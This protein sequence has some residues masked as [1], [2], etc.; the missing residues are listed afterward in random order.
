[1]TDLSRVGLGTVQFGMHY[2]VSNRV[3][4]PDEREVAAILERAV[5]RGVRYLDTASA[6]GDAEILLGRHL[7]S[8]HNLRIVTKMPPVR[9]EHIGARHKQQWLDALALSLERLKVSA[10]Y[11]LLVHQAD[12]LDKPGWQYLAEALQEAQASG[13]VSH[14]GVS[15]YDENQLRLADSRFRSDLIQ[16]PLNALDLRLIASGALARLKA[17]G[18]E[19]HARSVFLQGVLLA[20]PSDLP[21][22][23]QPL[24]QRL[25]EM[26]GG[27]S[28]RGLSPLAACLA[29]VLRQTNVD[30]AI[31][32]VNSLTEF[33]EIAAAIAEVDN[34]EVDYDAMPPVDPIYLD[35]S[36]W[37][38]LAH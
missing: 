17:R 22:F 19:V 34:A 31:V 8:G 5:A 35:P 24:R 13:L 4:Q 12:D 2:G 14:I 1:M 29:F 23:F 6:Y 37:P 32:G 26:H 9:D 28:R 27:W 10:V 30:A 25:V 7:P 20:P 16:L 36:R 38:A 33:D 21:D 3:G 11:G 15:I 18:V